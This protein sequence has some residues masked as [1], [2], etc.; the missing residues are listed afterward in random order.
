M[1]HQPA[2]HIAVTDAVTLGND[3]PFVL[4]SGPCQ[5]E[6]REH[7]LM[8]AREVSGICADLGVPYVFKASFDKAN[9]SSLGGRRGVGLEQGLEIL[10][11][12]R[13][14]VGC[15][16]LTDVHTEAQCRPVAEVVDMLQIPAF[17]CR[18]TDFVLAV[19]EAAAEFGRTVNVKKGQF[20]APWDMANVVA[21]IEST[22]CQKMALV[23]RGVTFGYGNLVVD[24]RSLYEMAKTGY[25]VVMDATHAVQ[26]PGALGNASGGKR[27][28]VPVIAR[29]A[30][31]VGVA[32]LFMEVHDDPDNA[33]SDG[34][35][36]VQLDRLRDLLA[37]LVALDQVRK[38]LDTSQTVGCR[39]T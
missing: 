37:G 35:N 29:A 11:E 4:Q 10:A 22:G 38:Q 34:P 16:V 28:Y 15:P 17:L 14:S 30:V 5:I 32:G 39:S 27:E 36:S 3:L 21:K 2:K 33:A 12:I 13:A 25:P 19:G 31:G 7:A 23:E 18:Q 8:L 26:M 1:T 20:L 6:S 24:P 9:R